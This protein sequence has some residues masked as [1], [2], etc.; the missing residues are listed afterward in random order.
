MIDFSTSRSHDPAIIS[1]SDVF[2]VN[3]YIGTRILLPVCPFGSSRPHSR[4]NHPFTESECGVCVLAAAG[5]VLR[6]GRCRPERVRA[7]GNPDPSSPE[8]PEYKHCCSV[9]L[10]EKTHVRNFEQSGFYGA[11]KASYHMARR[12]RTRLRASDH[13]SALRP[14]S[15]RQASPPDWL[16]S[17]RRGS[18]TPTA[19]GSFFP[20]SRRVTIR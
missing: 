20:A 18:A 17:A 9:A 8:C 16:S 6:H 12:L 19:A 11:H 10:K 15:F 1:A 14:F 4:V 7:Q 2:R 5:Y 3:Q 13:P